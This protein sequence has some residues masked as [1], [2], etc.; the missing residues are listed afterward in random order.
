MLVHK[1]GNLRVKNQ[2]Q[3]YQIT[4]R[5]PMNLSSTHQNIT[6]CL[7][8]IKINGIPFLTTITRHNMYRIAK[9]IPQ[10][11]IKAY[12]SKLDNVFR[13]YDHAGFKITTIHCD[14]EFCPLMSELKDTYNVT[15]NY[16]NPQEHVPEAE[17][18]NRVIIER[19][20]ASFHRLP[21]NKLPKNIVK[22]LAMEIAKKIIFSPKG[23]I[24]PYYSPRMIMH[25]K[26][27]D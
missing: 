10:E 25:Q 12:R 17:R 23:G 1:K 13:I 5:F 2:L 27:L 8:G 15:M 9:W 26:T 7:D 14:N 4:L 21:F 24:S 11:T 6:L 22:L 16:A 3:W 19:F 20:R 18:N